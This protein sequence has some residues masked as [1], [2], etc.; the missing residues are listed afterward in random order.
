MSTGS[1]EQV[2]VQCPFYQ[3]DDGRLQ[4]RCEGFG[5]ARSLLLIYARTK[6]FKN[7]MNTSAAITT[8]PAKSTVS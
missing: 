8:S 7:R 6:Y 3:S 4:I 5:M 1:Y 2:Y